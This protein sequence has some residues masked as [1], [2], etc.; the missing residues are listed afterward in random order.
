MLRRQL[1]LKPGPNKLACD[2]K[3]QSTLALSQDLDGVQYFAT[4][5]HFNPP[6]ERRVDLLHAWH[7]DVLLLLFK[8]E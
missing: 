7:F 8:L 6:R 1:R 3:S 5:A 2:N 4:G